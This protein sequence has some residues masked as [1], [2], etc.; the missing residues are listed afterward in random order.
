[1]KDNWFL[2]RTINPDF[3]DWVFVFKFDEDLISKLFNALDFSYENLS[4]T[5]EFPLSPY[6]AGIYQVPGLFPESLSDEFDKNGYAVLRD[7]SL[8]E[9]W[10]KIGATISLNVHPYITILTGR[11]DATGYWIES[12]DITFLI[13]EITG[14]RTLS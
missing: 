3:W 8:I 11:V 9:Q 13:R 1:M 12:K 7:M 6:R 5:V 4:A 14:W 2:V 10:K